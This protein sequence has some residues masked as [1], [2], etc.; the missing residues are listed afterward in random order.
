[1][2]KSGF[3]F[4]DRSESTSNNFFHNSRQNEK[5]AHSV[6]SDAAKDDFICKSWTADGYRETSAVEAKA[7][8]DKLVS[9]RAEIALKRTKRKMQKSTRTQLSAV[10]V[11]DGR[12]TEADAL[13]LIERI[14]KLIDTKVTQFAI[15]RDEGYT[16]DNEKHINHH[17]HLEM[18]GLDSAGASIQRQLKRSVLQQVQAITAETLDMQYTPG[19]KQ[20]RVKHKEYKRLKEEER[21][22]HSETYLRLVEVTKIARAVNN[23]NAVLLK[24]NSSL[25]EQVLKLKETTEVLDILNNELRRELKASSA[26]RAD[27]AELEAEVKAIRSQLSEAKE[28]LKHAKNS[29]D[30]DFGL[31]DNKEIIKAELQVEKREHQATKDKLEQAIKRINELSRSSGM[32]F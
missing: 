4:G 9:E 32:G 8:H 12:H 3:T 20:K 23:K 10:V 22:A 28:E 18:L 30:D 1:M 15:H 17:L 7:M 29:D 6:F 5:R 25:K 19:S 13:K 14:E 11:L 21:K 16:D 24:E 26:K 27:Y 2:R 31:F